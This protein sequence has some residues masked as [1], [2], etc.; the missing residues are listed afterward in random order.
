LAILF[1]CTIAPAAKGYA[2]HLIQD[3]FSLDVRNKM[4]AKMCSQR[5]LTLFYTN[6]IICRLVVWVKGVLRKRWKLIG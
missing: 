1:S 6:L 3:L 2:M 5:L 4:N